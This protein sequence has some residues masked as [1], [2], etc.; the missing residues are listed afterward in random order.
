MMH[1]ELFFLTL[2]PVIINRWRVKS[3][4]WREGTIASR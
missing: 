3:E 4:E 2:Q 1:Y